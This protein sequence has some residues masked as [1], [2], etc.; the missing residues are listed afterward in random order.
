MLIVCIIYQVQYL[1]ELIVCATFR[2][3]MN[4]DMLQRCSK[5]KTNFVSFGRSKRKMNKNSKKKSNTINT[6]KLFHAFFISST[7]QFKPHIYASFTTFNS[8]RRKLVYTGIPYYHILYYIV[9]GITCL[10]AS[11]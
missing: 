2:F 1:A 7:V 4:P 6:A 11:L 9:C 5:C 3:V 8:S 10:S